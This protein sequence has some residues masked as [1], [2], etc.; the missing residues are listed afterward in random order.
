MRSLHGRFVGPLVVSED[1]SLHGLVD[2]DVSVAEDVVFLHH[3][4][5]AG[6]LSIAMGATVNL[7]G[8]VAGSVR[9]RGDLTV[10]GNV[11]G[12]IR[13]TDGGRARLARRG[14]KWQGARG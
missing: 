10:H 12:E 13:N 11:R 4:M 5:I 14:L 3:G 8:M 6:D 7:M 1:T 9:N 2:G